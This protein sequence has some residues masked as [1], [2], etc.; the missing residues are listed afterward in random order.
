MIPTVSG[1]NVDPFNVTFDDIHIGDIAHAL[2]LVNRFNG[3]TRHPISVAQHSVFV[4]RLVADVPTEKDLPSDIGMQG[5]LHDASEAYLGDI[6]TF[7]KQMDEFAVFR[8]MEA[9]FQSIIFACFGCPMVAHPEVKKADKLMARFE[10]FKMF[11]PDF[12]FCGHK[13]DYPPLTEE[14][15]KRVGPWATW[16]WRQAKDVFLAEFE[17]F[18]T[19]AADKLFYRAGPDY[20]PRP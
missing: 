19:D 2:S 12:H 13:S 5:P 3:A 6:T 4:A 17:R 20:G 10:A 14:E 18:T 1:K 9:Y 16:T 8:D 7:L 15:I 11:G